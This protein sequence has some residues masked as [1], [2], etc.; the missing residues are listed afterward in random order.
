MKAVISNDYDPAV[1]SRKGTGVGLENVRQ[2]IQLA[3]Q[4][5]GTVQWKGEAGV[6]KVTI[7]IPRIFV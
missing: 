6:F 7:L 3:Y 4:G 5:K 1:P 2:R